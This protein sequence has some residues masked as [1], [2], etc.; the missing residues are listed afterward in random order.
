[1]INNSQTSTNSNPLLRESLSDPLPAWNRYFLRGNRPDDDFENGSSVLMGHYLIVI[2]SQKIRYDSWSPNSNCI[3]VIDLR[4][5]SVQEIKANQFL[6][7]SD[8]LIK[9]N[10]SQ[11]MIC[12]EGYMISKWEILTIQSFQRNPCFYFEYLIFH[13]AFKWVSEK[14][15]A[16]GPQL[17]LQRHTAQ[18]YQE[19]LYIYGQTKDYPYKNELWSLNLSN[20]I[21]FYFPRT[22][23]R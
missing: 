23:N 11:M 16:K 6:L 14:V 10:E 7:P 5:N 15:Q 19:S 22:L 17:D 3:L 2:V 9:C 20:I 21:P 12:G 18:I 8:T 1:M 4:D 13:K